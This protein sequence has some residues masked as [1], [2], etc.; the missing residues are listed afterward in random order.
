MVTVA[1]VRVATTK[2]YQ[3][4][5]DDWSEGGTQLATRA[6]ASGSRT[7]YSSAIRHYL[8]HG[9]NTARVVDALDA[10]MQSFARR[11]RGGLA[12]KSLLRGP[13][14][15]RHWYSWRLSSRSSTGYKWRPLSGSRNIT[16]QR[17]STP[18]VG[19]WN[20]LENPESFWHGRGPFSLPHAPLYT[21]CG[22]EMP[23]Q[24]AGDA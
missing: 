23:S 15:W 13:R 24:S 14:Q 20:S 5:S 16:S 12:G 3:V 19:T 9:S 21:L 6:I 18:K 10:R 8:V 22:W 4:C 17:G 11:C 7:T 2:Y 1:D